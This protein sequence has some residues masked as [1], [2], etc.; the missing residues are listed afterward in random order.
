MLKSSLT[1]GKLPVMT[2]IYFG[3]Q[4]VLTRLENKAYL[5]LKITAFELP[6]PS[7]E[8]SDG[9]SFFP[10]RRSE[11]QETPRSD[12]GHGRHHPR[13][14][15]AALFPGLLPSQGDTYWA[16]AG[17]EQGR[18]ITRACSSTSPSDGLKKIGKEAIQ[19]R[20]L[21]VTAWSEGRAESFCFFLR[22]QRTSVRRM[23]FA[24]SKAQ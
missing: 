5:L 6:L 18:L 15:G 16:H 23:S 17:N 7:L 9:I 19:F 14:C 3:K 10:Q 21:E 12:R 11:V 24:C 2:V 4:H 20:S 22:I 13:S 1:V 8:S